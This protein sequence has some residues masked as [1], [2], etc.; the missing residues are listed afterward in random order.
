MAQSPGLWSGRGVAGW[1]TPLPARP[2]PLG[3]PLRSLKSAARPR[4]HL[5]L[6]SAPQVN[7]SLMRLDCSKNAGSASQLCECPQGS[8]WMCKGVPLEVQGGS[9]SP[10]QG[11]GLPL[12]VQGAPLVRL[13]MQRPGMRLP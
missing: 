5:T 3:K 7:V 8:P 12:E 10:S 4:L 13:R 6:R 1:L 11:K 2:D 9:G